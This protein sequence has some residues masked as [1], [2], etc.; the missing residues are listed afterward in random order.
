MNGLF[1][2]LFP[3]Y[4]KFIL[5]EII[6]TC[7]NESS[8]H[9]HICNKNILYYR[10]GCIGGNGIIYFLWLKRNFRGILS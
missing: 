7:Q 1:F 3:F 2:I 10:A 6:P 9:S 8:P 4:D 5:T